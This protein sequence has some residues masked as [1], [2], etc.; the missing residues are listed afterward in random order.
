MRFLVL[1]R[2]PELEKDNSEFKIGQ[3]TDGVRPSGYLVR[4]TINVCYDR[5]TF[6]SLTILIEFGAHD[7]DNSMCYVNEFHFQ[8]NV[9]SDWKSIVLSKHNQLIFFFRILK[10]VKV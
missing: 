1:L 5:R 3:E 8:S 9:T 2:Q 6:R 4:D 10:T 7:R